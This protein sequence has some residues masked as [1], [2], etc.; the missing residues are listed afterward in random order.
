[1]TRKERSG[2]CP[3]SYHPKREAKLKSIIRGSP[4]PQFV[5]N[6]DR[7]TI[8]WNHALEKYSRSKLVKG[9]NEFVGFFRAALL[10]DSGGKMI[11]AVGTL[12]DLTGHEK[13]QEELEKV[14]KKLLGMNRKLSK[15]SLVDSHTGLFNHRYFEE[16]A[17]SEFSRAKRNVL[18]L[19]MVMIDI[20]YFKSINDVYGHR[21][22]DLVLKQFAAQLKKAVRRYDS[23][24]RYGGEEFVIVCPGASRPVTLLLA[25]RILDSVTKHNFGDKAR[26]IRLKIS[27]G[28]ASYPEDEVFKS[29]DL[30]EIADHALNKAKEDGGDR[31]YSSLDVMNEGPPHSPEEIE[32]INSLKEKINNLN[33]RSSQGIIEAVCAFART[34]KLRDRYTGQHAEGTVRFATDIGRELGLSRK[35]LEIAGQAA[36][37][38]DLGKVGINENILRKRA[39]LTKNEL[40]KVKRHPS[41]AADILRNV[42]YL[43]DIV[44]AI[45]YHHERW[46]GKGY[47]KGLRGEEIPI[48][49]RIIAL[50]DVFQALISNRPYRKAYS[51]N[52]AIKL[53][54]NASGTQFD[55]KV[56]RVFSRI[57]NKRHYSNRHP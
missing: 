15:L 6:K 51:R 57:I 9:A 52:S 40:E 54:E 4:I 14:N 32:G 28:V 31:V 34:M 42:H 23:I 17:G 19:S 20:D 25:Q 36:I 30:F 56:V 39:K 35:E 22:G 47:P 1:M 50:A 37:L 8:Y 41:I 7:K 11:G 10:R 46:D 33:R 48:V 29:M 16:I 44:P 5:I 21:F 3:Y 49:A 24:I 43:R 53:I 27:I 18:P 55:P 45:L 12:E 2:M 26:V 13:A 38:H